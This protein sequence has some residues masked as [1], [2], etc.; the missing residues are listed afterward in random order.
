MRQKKKGR[1]FKFFDRLKTYTTLTDF[2]YSRKYVKKVF[3]NFNERSIK[4]GD[5]ILHRELQKQKRILK[6]FISF[7]RSKT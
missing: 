4:A 2:N 5:A 3:N 6:N 1:I 7:N